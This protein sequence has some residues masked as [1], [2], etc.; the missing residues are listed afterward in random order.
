MTATATAM[1]LRQ[2]RYENK[3][4]W[5]NPA[6][7][8]FTF[9]FPL[10]FLVISN[11]ISNDHRFYVPAVAAFSVVTACYTNIAMSISFARDQGVL[12]RKRGTP[13]P[14]LAYLVARVLH[15]TLIALLL[16]AI[17][18]AA[19]AV[20]YDVVLPTR[21]LPAL[22]VT[23]VLGAA[24]FAALGLAITAAIPNAQAAPAIVN[25]SILPLLFVS[26]VFITPDQSPPWMT[27]IAELFPI[28]HFSDAMLSAFNPG[29]GT[30]WE[31]IDLA[32]VA[33]WGVAGLLFAIR[34][35]SW[36]PRR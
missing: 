33:G 32:F 29:A 31:P 34:Y 19:G 17:V 16:V 11:A 18:S 25:G 3:V 14:A 24:T 20:L 35:F 26:D 28:K 30:G 6:A 36:E 13:L 8:F 2:V 7:A 10:M 15:A 27:A 5:R 4:F 23:L 1:T 12:K 9:A 22:L 21:T